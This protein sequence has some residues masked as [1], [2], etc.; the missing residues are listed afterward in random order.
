M[1]SHSLNPLVPEQGAGAVLSERPIADNDLPICLQPRECKLSAWN[2]SSVIKAENEMKVGGNGNLIKW[3]PLP[4]LPVALKGVGWMQG[5]RWGQRGR[6]RSCESKTEQEEGRSSSVFFRPQQVWEMFLPWKREC[7]G[8]EEVEVCKG[9][10]RVLRSHLQPFLFCSLFI[11]FLLPLFLTICPFD[12]SGGSEI[13]LR[14]V[15][16]W[17]PWKPSPKHNS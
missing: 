2:M 8:Y 1:K 7:K 5:P 11:L 10:Q 12:F 17:K 3:W 13:F 4:R 14:H 6:N 16:L 15:M 9:A